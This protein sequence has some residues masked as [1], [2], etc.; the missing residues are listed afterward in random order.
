MSEKNLQLIDVLAAHRR[1]APYVNKTPLV[2]SHWL[3]GLA[4]ADVMLKLENVQVTGSFKYRGALNALMW[5]KEQHITKIF[6]AT[7][8]NHGLG[9]AEASMH[10]ESDVTI[11][12]PVTASPV[13]KQRLKSYSVSTIDHGEDFDICEAFAKR[14]ATQKNGFFLSAYNHPA[15]KA[16][17]DNV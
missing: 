1:I 15:V 16:W 17:P 14:M 2:K 3:S 7:A 10:T 11:C 13:K 9:L 12:L 8:G 4:Q 6:S 5:A